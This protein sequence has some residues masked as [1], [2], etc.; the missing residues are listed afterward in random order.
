MLYLVGQRIL[1]CV[2]D[3]EGCF[4]FKFASLLSRTIPPIQPIN[5]HKSSHESTVFTIFTY[6][7]ATLTR[8]V[9]SWQVLCNGTHKLGWAIFEDK[10]INERWSTFLVEVTMGLQIPV[11]DLW[12]HLCTHQTAIKQISNFIHRVTSRMG[13]SQWTSSA[14]GLW[15]CA[16]VI[17]LRKANTVI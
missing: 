6:S 8:S 12:S 15:Q 10:E 4:G 3:S 2:P 17:I 7:A 13:L 9:L 11:F 5:V 1:G 14:Y 16:K